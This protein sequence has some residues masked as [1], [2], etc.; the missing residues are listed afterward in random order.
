MEKWYRSFAYIFIALL[1]GLFLIFCLRFFSK[2]I[3]VNK[4]QIHSP[5]LQYVADYTQGDWY[6]EICPRS[7][8]T[9]QSEYSNE[10]KYYDAIFEEMCTITEED[11]QEEVD[12]EEESV[13]QKLIDKIDH[14]VTSLKNVLEKYA[15]DK[16]MLTD[17][18]DWIG[19]TYD[20]VLGWE[21]VYARED[22]KEFDLST[23]YVWMVENKI[24][25][26]EDYLDSI[27]VAQY[28]EAKGT[29]YLR[30]FIPR[31]ISPD[32]LEVPLGANE[33]YHYNINLQIQELENYDVDYYDLRTDLFVHGWRPEQGYFKNNGHWTPESGFYSAGLIADYLNNQYGFEFRD[34]TF[35]INNYER[36]TFLLNDLFIDEDVSILYPLKE[37]IWLKMRNF[38]LKEEE[39][40][41]FNNI[42]FDESI[43]EEDFRK[44]ILDLY[45]ISRITNTHL[46][47]I[48]NADYSN[49]QTILIFHNSMSWYI[50]P[51]LVL[52]CKEV[53]YSSGTTTQQKEYLI[54]KIQPDI[55]IEINF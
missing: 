30:V 52:D 55:V 8:E 19:D 37:N 18:F 12:C 15:N 6:G 27:E 1:A 54:D 2:M 50:I 38:E 29:N 14:M 21:V 13:I 40:G 5:M 25:N 34:E 46:G 10:Y 24:N 42:I 47:M 49:D 16:Y 17:V 7:E 26:N 41:F 35:D 3:L 39:E 20:D 53:F 45:C 31:R 4:F 23:G 48:E 22:G 11:L 28:C 36:R 51:Y 44:G 43:I 9:E 33:Y 32:N